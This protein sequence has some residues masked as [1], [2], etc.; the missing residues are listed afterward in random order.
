VPQFPGGSG[1]A[2][3]RRAGADVC[4]CQ[5]PRLGTIMVSYPKLFGNRWISTVTNLSPQCLI[6]LEMQMMRP[7]QCIHSPE[8]ALAPPSRPWACGFALDVAVFDGRPPP[9]E[10]QRVALE[11]RVEGRDRRRKAPVA[12]PSIASAATGSQG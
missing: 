9:P 3:V 2:A 5:A 4:R 11:R 6:S 1:G 8:V 12:T 10:V 7:N